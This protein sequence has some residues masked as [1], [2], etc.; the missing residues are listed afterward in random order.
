ME[1]WAFECIEPFVERRI[2]LNF[3]AVRSDLANIWCRKEDD[4][5]HPIEKFLLTFG[6]SGEKKEQTPE[7]Q[8]FIMGL[9]AIHQNALMEA[10]NAD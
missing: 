1:C 2:D 8:Q 6:L 7:Q 3:A 4:P 9:L 5:V 10:G